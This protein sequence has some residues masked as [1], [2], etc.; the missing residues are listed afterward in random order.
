MAVQGQEADKR[1][2]P[3]SRPSDL[4]LSSRKH[5]FLPSEPRGRFQAALL[6]TGPLSLGARAAYAL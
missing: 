6:A 1:L 3:S 4:C 2:I 5:V